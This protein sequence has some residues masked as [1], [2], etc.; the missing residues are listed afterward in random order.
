MGTIVSEATP[1]PTLTSVILYEEIYMK[2]GEK[3]VTLGL[4][5]LHMIASTCVMREVLVM[6]VSV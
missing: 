2:V 4:A 3:I 6:R 1:P 5:M